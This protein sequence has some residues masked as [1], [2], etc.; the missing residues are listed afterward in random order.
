MKGQRHFVNRVDVLCADHRGF[1][2]VTEERDLAAQLARQRFLRATEENVGR[3]TDLAQ[4]AY[5]VLRWF[6]FQFAGGSD[7][8]HE[9]DVNKQRIAGAFFVTHL[10]DRFEKRQ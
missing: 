5:G 3:D 4:V 6:C 10:S 8:G 1:F 2:N 9:C 7:V